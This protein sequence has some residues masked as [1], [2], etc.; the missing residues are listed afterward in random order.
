VLIDRREL[1]TARVRLRTWRLRAWLV[2]SGSRWLEALIFRHGDGH[3]RSGTGTVKIRKRYD[4]F[5]ARAER[6]PGVQL[7]TSIQASFLSFLGIFDT[8]FD[9]GWSEGRAQ[10]FGIGI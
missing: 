10:E 3:V 7:R 5:R 8:E 6:D 1:R 9:V 4:W 2:T